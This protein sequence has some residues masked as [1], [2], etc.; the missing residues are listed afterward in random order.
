MLDAIK[1]KLLAL[2]TSMKDRKKCE[3]IL[4]AWW[5]VN[6][7]RQIL[8]LGSAMMMFFHKNAMSNDM[9]N[10]MEKDQLANMPICGTCNIASSGIL[11]I[12]I[13]QAR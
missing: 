5:Q 11:K 12:F 1:P 6:S 13:F 10:F 3:S 9:M 7:M 4:K 8:Q 2:S